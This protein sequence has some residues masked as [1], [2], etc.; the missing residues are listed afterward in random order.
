VSAI[1]SVAFDP[2]GTIVRCDDCRALYRP[3]TVEMLAGRN[4]GRRASCRGR[5]TV[6]STPARWGPSAAS[7]CRR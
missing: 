2:D 4:G 1:A 3:G 7:S 6:R 5:S